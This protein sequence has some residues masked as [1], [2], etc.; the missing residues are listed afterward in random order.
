MP[1]CLV[2]L[3]CSRQCAAECDPVPFV[4]PYPQ[5]H[6][7]GGTVGMLWEAAT[8]RR[9]HRHFIV[10]RREDWDRVAAAREP[11]QGYTKRVEVIRAQLNV[12]VLN[13]QEHKLASQLRRVCHPTYPARRYKNGAGR[14]KRRGRDIKRDAHLTLPHTKGKSLAGLRRY[15]VRT[16]TPHKRIE[17]HGASRCSCIDD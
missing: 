14:L 9:F 2:L 8:W 6:R 3:L 15:R 7:G 17:G 5:R 4:E 12:A 11:V 13:A 16:L 10:R 1:L